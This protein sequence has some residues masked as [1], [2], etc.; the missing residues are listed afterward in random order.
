MRS[1]ERSEQERILTP[2][3]SFTLKKLMALF[4]SGQEKRKESHF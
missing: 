3:F 4:V 2:N 1:R